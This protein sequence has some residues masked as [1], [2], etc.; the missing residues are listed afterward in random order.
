MRTTFFIKFLL[1]ILFSVD[2]N[3]Q[4]LN[5]QVTVV[6][7]AKLALSSTDKEVIDQLKLTINEFMNST[8][9]TKD[10]FSLEERINC[11]LQLQI[12]SMPSP[13]MFAGSLQVQASRPVFNSSYN[14]TLFNFLDQDISFSFSRNALLAYAPNQFRDNLTSLLAFYAYFII[15]MDYDSFSL[16]GGTP[17]FNEAQQIVSN[18]QSSEI[19]GWMSNETSKKNRYWIVD[20]VLH[21]LFEPLRKC[22]YEYHRLGLDGMYDNKVEARK[23]ISESLLLLN[24]VNASRPASINITSFIQSKSTELKNLFMDATLVEKTEVVSLLKKI[25]P[26]N[27]SKYQ[28]ILN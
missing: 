16:K 4:E 25:D 8:K 12:T 1:F 3:S 18:A 2:L 7:D 23:K 6:S 19:K 11:N 20:N 14:T 15:G 24:K 28:E 22:N 10:K 26:V 17:Y 21:Q 27:S 5:C 9:W 13:G